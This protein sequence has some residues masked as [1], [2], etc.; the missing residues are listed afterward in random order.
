MS[1]TVD[2]YPSRISAPAGFIPR[3][4]PV[5]YSDVRPAR[6]CPL[7]ESEIGF[8]QENGYL[9]FESLFPEAEVA[10]YQKELL[11]LRDSEEVK[12]GRDVI[13]EPQSN[14]I[15]S[16]FAVHRHNPVFRRLAGDG[17]IVGRVSYLL[18]S[19]VYM[20]Q[21]RIN[22]KPGIHGKEF[23]W[24]SDFETWHMEDG[25]PRMRA[26]SCSISLSE[27][28]EFNGPLMLIPGSHRHFLA[29]VGETPENHYEQSLRKQEYGVPDAESLKWLVDQ[30][31]IISS[32]GPAGSVTFFECNMMHGSNSNI[33][34]WPR[35][36]V[37]FV[38]NS[39]ENVLVK[40]FCGLAPRPEHIASRDFEVLKSL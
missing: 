9:C 35:S 14:E 15:R 6:T 34:P 25:M 19:P 32:K 37:F 24:H 33:S 22:Y 8:Y 5:V 11:R 31:G 13:L 10:E 40:P 2:F 16:I 28:N 3:K 39:V 26:I 21:S 12:R 18:G 27:N 17:R 23:F 36:N 4:D 29:C 1:A 38:Y 30:G 20:H 7:T